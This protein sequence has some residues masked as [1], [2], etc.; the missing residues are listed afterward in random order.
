MNAEA[1]IRSIV[2]N[3][4]VETIYFDRRRGI[5]HHLLLLQEARC[6]NSHTP[7]KA[8][9]A[10]N[11]LP[12]ISVRSTT[13]VKSTINMSKESD[14]KRGSEIVVSGVI[15]TDYDDFSGD[16]MFF[17]IESHETQIK[18]SL[19]HRILD[20][21]KRGDSISKLLY[22]GKNTFYTLTLGHEN[23]EKNDFEVVK[24]SSS[25]N[26]ARICEKYCLARS[27]T[28]SDS[29]LSKLKEK[30]YHVKNFAIKN[31]ND[32]TRLYIFCQE[33]IEYEKYLFKKMKG[34]EIL[35]RSKVLDINH[36]LYLIE[37][38]SRYTVLSEV[39]FFFNLYRE[40]ISNKIRQ[41]NFIYVSFLLRIFALQII[42]VLPKDQDDFESRYKS[43]NNLDNLIFYF[44]IF[45]LRKIFYN[46][47]LGFENF[48]RKA[49]FYQLLNILD[50][51]QKLSLENYEVE[52]YLLF[53]SQL[54]TMFFLNLNDVRYRK[55]IVL[56]GIVCYAKAVNLNDLNIYLLR[57]TFSNLTNIFSIL[58]NLSHVF[59]DKKHNIFYASLRESCERI[60]IIT[61]KEKI[62]KYS[63]AGESFPN[64]VSIEKYIWEF[65]LKLEQAIFKNYETN[66]LNMEIT[67]DLIE[68]LNTRISLFSL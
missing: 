49:Y 26:K 67:D 56:I 5:Q 16:K 31:K 36:G 6:I 28:S 15:K 11:D 17:Y 22:D 2:L 20:I 19:I 10:K 4:T 37:T 57:L 25:D 59:L 55:I 9:H 21:V 27:E 62:D 29:F 24:I 41:N 51:R 65:L 58:K 3:K 54:N 7:F 38:D 43:K 50:F 32:Y 64:P 68:K 45:K 30:I 33:I 8:I 40:K 61:R 53:K 35:E 1:Y 12:L 34:K 66:E 39:F 46:I 63:K 52:E 44:E 13:V 23:I 47:L 60:Y 14:L 42:K 48:N 18:I